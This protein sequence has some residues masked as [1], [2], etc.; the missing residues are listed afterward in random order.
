MGGRQGG[1]GAPPPPPLAR[2]PDPRKTI[3]NLPR[4]GGLGKT[5]KKEAAQDEGSHE[6]RGLGI[7]PEPGQERE[8]RAKEARCVKPES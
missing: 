7:A 4:G 1:R 3:G 6:L 2:P 5:R 8:F